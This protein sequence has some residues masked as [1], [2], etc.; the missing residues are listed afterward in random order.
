MKKVLFLFAALS[1]AFVSC[2]NDD[3]DNN[4]TNTSNTSGNNGGN[5]TSNSFY[6]NFK[7][8]GASYT[9]SDAGG[10]YQSVVGAANSID[11][12][13]SCYNW[14]G[15]MYAESGG[16]YE[17]TIYFKNNCF[18]NED[19]D[20]A[21]FFALFDE[22]SYDYSDNVTQGIGFSLYDYNNTNDFLN[23]WEVTQP[24]SSNFTITS[25][26]Q[27]TGLGYPYVTLTG[28]FNC[29]LG[30]GAQITDGTFRITIE[31]I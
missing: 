27:H 2:N 24:A 13:I 22:T 26:T 17:P 28:T 29:S 11:S 7:L 20:D 15:S 30:S 12:P 4:P 19:F 6:I 18:L 8:N 10:V 14:D 23:T 31:K 1:M 25:V 16:T 3:D 5:N 21:A 9:C